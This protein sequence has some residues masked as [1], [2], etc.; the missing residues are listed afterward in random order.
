MKYFIMLINDRS[1]VATE[2]ADKL[3]CRA[4]VRTMCPHRRDY[5]DFIDVDHRKLWG[6]T[7]LNG[8]LQ[9]KIP[10]ALALSYVPELVPVE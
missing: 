8:R 1:I 10:A 7:E 4:V 6:R 3:F 5:A 2:V 9:I